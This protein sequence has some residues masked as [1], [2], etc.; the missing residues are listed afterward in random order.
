MEADIRALLEELPEKKGA[1]IPLLQ[2]VQSELG[3]ISQDD[4][5]AISEAL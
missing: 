1:L 4:L 5:E 2:G 3:Y